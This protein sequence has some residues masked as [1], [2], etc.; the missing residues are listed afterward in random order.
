MPQHSS[1]TALVGRRAEVRALDEVLRDVRAGRS[2]VLVVR[3]EAGVGK[4]ALLDHVSDHAAPARVVRTAGAEPES[5]IAYSALQQ[6]CAPL[7]DRL[8][9]L[10][11][12]QRDALS[13][14]FGLGTGEPPTALVIGLA[15]LGLLSEA[16]SDKPLVCVVDDAQWLDRMSEVVLTFVAR[17]LD[18]ES[19][20]LVFGARTSGEDLALADLP[21]L[22]VG[23]L[24]PAEARAL[25]DSVLIGPV[26]EQVRE[27]IV[28]ETHGNPLALLEL[29]RGLSPAELA[30]GFGSPS[31]ASL[32]NRVEAGF[33]AR[34]AVLPPDTRRLVLTAAL[35]PVGDVTLLWRAC[36]R[37]GVAPDAAGPAEAA[38]LLEIGAR[39][40]FRHPLARSAAWRSADPAALR[41]VRA[42]L[43]DVTDPELEPDR[44][45]WHR[46]HAAVGPDEAVAAELE[47]SAERALA[48]GGRSA[49]AAFLKRAA[50]LTPDPKQRATRVLAAASAQLAAGAL[51]DVPDLLAAAELG[52]LDPVQ[53]A[54]LERLRA[55][56][57]FAVDPGRG[58][59]PP[60][61]AAARRLEELDVTAARETYLSALGAAMQA[62]RFEDG[63]TRRVAE[64]A[65]AV[66]VGDDVVG[67]MLTGLATRYLDGFADAVEPFRRALD[68]I[69][70][71]EDLNLLWIAG[72]VSQE[73]CHDAAWWRLTDRA[74]RHGRAT[75]ALSLLPT[76]LTFRAVALVWAGRFADASSLSDEADALAH[77]TG[78]AA[79]PSGPMLLAAYRGI[80]RPALELIDAVVADAEARRQGRLIG[81]ASYCRALLLNGLGR[82]QAAFEAARA[83][84]EYEDLSVYSWT[85]A[86]LAEAA[87][88]TGDVAAA[89]DARDRLAVR[90]TAAG[91]DWSLGLQA[92][93]DALVSAPHEVEG[94]FLEALERLGSTRLTLH[95]ARAQL[96]YGEWLRRENRRT[97]AR[98]H[99]RAAHE[100]Y[101][102]SGAEAFAERAA[103]ELAATGETVRK[104]SP[105]TPDELT[106]QEAQIA[107]LAV[108]GR[109]NPE[110]GA[111]LFLSPRTVEWHLRKVFT[112][113]GITSRRELA[114]AL[115]MS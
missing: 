51:N 115:R 46:A 38:G 87:L 36:E 43:A 96:Q 60:L 34:I 79:H 84:A 113:L 81:L 17:R 102:A 77:A 50:E 21:D 74:V 100:S 52:P 91:T 37:L 2:R 64:A 55:Q 56:T 92:G 93:V 107:R 61:L 109:T 30:F 68:A 32:A 5:E 24:A 15:V 72:P 88:R 62:G 13:T 26:D 98:E 112:K 47:R 82:Y 99:L 44:R 58:S 49:A 19:V 83:G 105:G 39:V 108:A 45:A 65:R 67:L 114:G 7:L 94:H 76:A 40:R 42:A 53:R 25:L 18:A 97:D 33:S 75:G 66:P 12:P 41:E 89:R 106:S 31:P 35:E 23:G 1:G 8:G 6:L 16:A 111:V 10:P 57:A 63:D 71:D 86:E 29:P 70:D 28:A 104:R 110:I 27:R 101:A 59:G 3:G 20:A 78:R 95:R 80:E 85:L 54:S 90:T 69:R 103:R 22:R 9:A 11:Q 73:I 4:S 48:R 14:A